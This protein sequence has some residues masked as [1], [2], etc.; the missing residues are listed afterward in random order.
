MGNHVCDEKC[1]Y[2]SLE[3]YQGNEVEECQNLV[4]HDGSHDCK[5]KNHTCMKICYLSDK[6]SNC[7]KSWCLKV[8]H[9]SLNKCNSPQH[10]CNM[11]C[12]LPSCKNPCVIQIHLGDHQNQ[13]CHEI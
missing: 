4:G 8:G 3:P 1:T 2:F 13:A 7:S 5:K 11:K 12:S 6:S 9:E 10:M